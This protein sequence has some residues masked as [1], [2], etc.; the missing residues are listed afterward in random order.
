LQAIQNKL[1][2][3]V[4]VAPQFP[5]TRFQGSKAKL[6]DWIWENIK[7]LPFDTA[8][9]AFGG[10]GAFAHMLKRHGKQVTY[11]D[12]LRFNHLIG[13]SL[14][15]NRSVTLSEEDIAWILQRHTDIR[16]PSFIQDTFRDIYYTDEEN[17]WLDQVV[18]NIRAIS[19]TYKQALAFF[20]LFQSCIIKRPFNLFHRRNL[21]I[22]LKDV[23]RSFGNKTTWDKPFEQWFRQFVAEA[24]QSVFDNGRH[25]EAL[26]LEPL[27]VKENYD[28]V[29]IDTPYISSKG[30]GV[31]YLH[32]YHFLEGIVIYEQWKEHIDYTRKHRPLKS[33]KSD[34]VDKNKIHSAFDKLFNHFK[35]SILVVSYRDNGIPS[36]TELLEILSKYKRNV[37]EVKKV[38][39]KYVLAL[40]SSSELLFIAE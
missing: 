11:N 5:G 3:N 4:A 26:N 20:A 32:F 39:Y 16:Y 6:V 30:V 31:D 33:V 36:E 1:L 2:E 25:N 7:D 17:A 8:L 24:N 28:L 10:T 18:T 22:R 29:Y 37:I 27:S 34:W 19:D 12:S 14:I 13:K 21:Y 35:D 38:N 40:D 23:Q 9:D 15:E